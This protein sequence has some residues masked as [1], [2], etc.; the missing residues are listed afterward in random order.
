MIPP[1]NPVGEY[2][3]EPDPTPQ[4][5]AERIA[6]IERL[7]VEARA[8]VAG[9]TPPQLDTKYRNWTVRQII[10]HLA[11]SQMNAFIRFRLALTEDT[12]TIKP[13]DE[14]R[15]AELPDM[16]AADVQLSLSLLG[17]L[18]ARWV[19]LLRSMTD[20]DFDRAYHHPEFQKT[21]RLADVLGIYAHHGR[22]HTAQIRWLRKE[23]GGD[24]RERLKCRDPMPTPHPGRLPG[25]GWGDRPL[26]PS[27]K[28]RG[29]RVR[30][31]GVARAAPSATYFLVSS[32]TASTI[33]S[34]SF[35]LNSP[36]P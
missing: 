1:Q 32:L 11:D 24:A 28:E 12:P 35:S 5:R 15:W 21:Y 30:G 20:A 3:P 23:N 33:L 36:L 27:S 34:A 9:L 19:L 6:E 22:H 25:T 26:S 8:A 16:K 18:H 31:E 13:Y 10:H 7:P 2:T 14:S 4:R 17:A 29:R